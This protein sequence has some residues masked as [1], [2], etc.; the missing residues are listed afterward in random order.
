MS[1]VMKEIEKKLND[2]KENFE[3][4]SPGVVQAINDFRAGKIDLEKLEEIY[5]D[6]VYK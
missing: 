4:K 6:S 1:N 5:N 3:K 2:K